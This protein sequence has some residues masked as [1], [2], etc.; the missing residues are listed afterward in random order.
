MAFLGGLKLRLLLINRL[1]RFDTSQSKSLVDCSF[2][3]YEYQ[4]PF[5]FALPVC[6]EKI[7]TTKQICYVVYTIG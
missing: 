7:V 3:P 5:L 4:H 1:L 6:L 2:P